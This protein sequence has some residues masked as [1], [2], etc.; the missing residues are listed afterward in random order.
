VSGPT[1]D[2][3]QVLRLA[4][5]LPIAAGLG[6]VLG[7]C[8]STR[9]G[10]GTGRTDLEGPRFLKAVKWGMVQ[11]DLSPLEK[12]Q[13]LAELGF[14]GV[15]LDSPSGVDREAVLAARD[16][17]GLDI[18]GVVD[19]VHWKWT[20]GDADPEVRRKGREGL[21]TA[22][23]DCAYYGGTTVLLVPGVVDRMIRY[24]QAY[25]R[26]QAEVRR[27]LP[28]AEELG[29]KIAF[30]NVW[31]QFLLS[32]ME[33]ARYVDEFD[34]DHVGWYLDVGNLVNFGHP[35]QWVRILGHRILKL[36]IKDYS[37]Q[38][39]N[40]EGLW[41]GFGVKIGEGSVDWPAV[42]AALEEIDYRGWATAEVGGGGRERL[43]DIA[44]RMDHVLAI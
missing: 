12:F 41:K 34:S 14:D 15:E 33:A 44:R 22:L 32:P 18:P 42:V 38:R 9:E 17:T 16:A 13:L 36:D 25:E 23:R 11:G 43:A 27:V 3:R 21:E 29:V 35:E 31:N 24:D 8:A 6:G 7:A 28:L 39:R 26:S 37:N 10:G 40:D 4:G 30:E 1:L 5:A 2:R 19:S 20:L